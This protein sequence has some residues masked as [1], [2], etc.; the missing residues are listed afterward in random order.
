MVA[1]HACSLVI[2][3]VSLLSSYVNAYGQIA[4]VVNSKNFCVFLPP[5]DSTNRII[6][7]TEWNAQAFC[8][9]NTPKAT[10]A[11]KLDPDFIQSAHYLKT[12]QYV[13]VT[14]QINP[15]KANLI[16][17]DEGG[18]MDIKAPK[19]SSCAG[20][21][22]YVNLIEPASN[23]YCM[24]CCN[25]DRTCNRGISEKGCSHIIPGDYSGPYGVNGSTASS[26]D[27]SS[28]TNPSSSTKIITT[29][30]S[31]KTS[32]T[33]KNTSAT[34]AKAAPTEDTAAN[35]AT[36]AADG[37][38]DFG[39]FDSI[40]AAHGSDASGTSDSVKASQESD[41]SAAPDSV[42]AS[43]E[44]NASE[45]P[46]SV[47]ASQGSNAHGTP[48]S[49]KAVRGSD[50]SEAS[51]TSNDT[52]GKASSDNADDT[53]TVSPPVNSDP[54]LS[55]TSR[56]PSSSTSAASGTT[57]PDAKM[58]SQNDKVFEQSINGA[59]QFRPTIVAL[60][61]IMVTMAMMVL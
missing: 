21:K 25:D 16:A 19:Y 8:I 11:G 57:T 20:W 24:R 34:S 47:Q 31:K 26:A 50:T 4:Q 51:N 23:T 12:D 15:A 28:T 46:D 61:T 52:S 41:A 29:Q 39:T 58:L 48:D 10:N 40:K 2:A 32:S 60:A 5:N 33:K 14:G 54:V 18:Q 45:A 27:A 56:P 59:G 42:K 6:A 38:N 37:S 22:F 9:G 30:K 1:I 35:D 49:A 43:Q 55:S 53:T 13:Q 36:R 17:T 3:T 7:D 44:S